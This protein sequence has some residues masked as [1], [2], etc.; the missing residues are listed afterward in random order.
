MLGMRFIMA[1][2]KKR[3]TNPM[4]RVLSNS[5]F[6][7]RIILNKKKYNRKKKYEME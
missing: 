5:L 2:K 6:K 3:N 1:K 7:L 4:A